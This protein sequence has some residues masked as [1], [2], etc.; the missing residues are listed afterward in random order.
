[1]FGIMLGGDISGRDYLEESL[2]NMERAARFSVDEASLRNTI[3]RLHFNLDSTPPTFMA[4]FGPAGKFVIPLSEK[5]DEEELSGTEKESDKKETEELNKKFNPL[6]DFKENYEPFYEE[7]VVVGIAH[8]ESKKLSSD[9]H[10][11]IYF[12]PTG[13]KDQAIVFLAYE[14]KMVSLEFDA[15][16]QEYN[17]EYYDVPEGTD[18]IEERRLKLAQDNF[19]KWQKK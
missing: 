4:E 1:M 12:Y 3:I 14:E 8:G 11:S 16:R 6:P 15:F 2:D 17:R 18:T 10:Y 13:E 9:G 7:V 19:Q 5:F